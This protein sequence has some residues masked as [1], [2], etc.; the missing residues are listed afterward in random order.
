MNTGVFIMIE[1]K[2]SIEESLDGKDSGIYPFLPCILQDLW[3][4]GADP[5]VMLDLIRE[6]IPRQNLKI[7][8]L[9]CGKGAVS[10]HIARELDCE[11]TAIDGVPEF[12]EEA[13]RYASQF[14]VKNKC[15]FEKGDIRLRISEFCDR[16]LVILGAIGP[17]FGTVYETLIQVEGCLT[18]GGYVLLDDGF[19]EDHLDVDYNRCPKR[20]EFYEQI[21]RAGF[22]IVR[23]VW[24]TEEKMNQSENLIMNCISQRIEELMEKHPVQK[25]I[26]DNYRKNQEY[27]SS[28]L[29]EVITCGTWL[30]KKKHRNPDLDFQANND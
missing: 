26:L 24:V 20:S 21:H 19:I 3:E 16:D 15:R 11:I 8:D 30:L 18:K 14:G 12:I 28:M 1:L 25:D 7:L 6:N 27:E 5:A 17:V 9:G 4:M 13:Q 22:E 2:K 10:V 29:Q 23:E